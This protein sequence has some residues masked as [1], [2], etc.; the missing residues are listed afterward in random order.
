MAENRYSD[1]SGRNAIARAL[2]QI[3]APPPQ[4]QL[5]PP[6]PV[7]QLGG[8][9]S[10]PAGMQQQPGIDQMLGITGQGGQEQQL[11]A[12]MGASGSGMAGGA[13]LPPSQSQAG[14][15]AQ[16]PP[17]MGAPTPGLPAAPNSPQ[18]LPWQWPPSS[19]PPQY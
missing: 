17:D 11:Q 1:R 4:T 10:R 18:D 8:M 12:G 19:Y 7:P 15:G 3:T 2:M 16:L 14:M 9:A 5:P 13:G 6:P